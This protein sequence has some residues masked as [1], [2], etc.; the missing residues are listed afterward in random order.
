M[1]FAREV[2]TEAHIKGQRVLEVGSRDINGSLRS[3]LMAFQPSEYVGID[4]E[5]GTGVDEVC[6]VCDVVKR[7]GAKRWD[8]IICT[9][10]LEHI[11]DWRCAV[12]NIKRA[13]KRRGL[14]F[15]T[16]RSP[17][18]PY[19]AYP[20][21]F[22]RFGNGD[23]V[24]LFG[25]MDFI[26]LQNDPQFPGVFLLAERGVLEKPPDLSDYEVHSI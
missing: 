13:L 18:Y 11:K 25:E 17:G 5:R 16:T 24:V 15:L 1:A 2:L 20:N 9:E 22:W 3:Y 23:M 8:V 12:D 21:D 10:T 26:R 6:D 7:Y 19:H 4:L 14:L